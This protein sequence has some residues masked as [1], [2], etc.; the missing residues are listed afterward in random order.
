[1][2][3]KQE[4]HRTKKINKKKKKSKKHIDLTCFNQCDLHILTEINYF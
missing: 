4:T 3:I 2:L 1:M